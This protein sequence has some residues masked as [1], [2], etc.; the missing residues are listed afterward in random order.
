MSINI[1][2]AEDEGETRTA[3][4]C[5]ASAQVEEQ[6]HAKKMAPTVRTDGSLSDHSECTNVMRTV[7]ERVVSCLGR[8]KDKK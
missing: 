3:E 4:A 6:N 8:R 2:V 5:L 1:R 7:R